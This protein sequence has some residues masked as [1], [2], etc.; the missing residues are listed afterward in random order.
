MTALFGYELDD[1]ARFLLLAC[2]G[3]LLLLLAT[4]ARR[5]ILLRIA[6]RQ[7]PRRRAQMLLIT[8]GLALGASIITSVFLTGDTVQTA[9]RVQVVEGLGRVDE[10]VHVAGGPYLPG[11]V[12]LTNLS[13][14]NT[15]APNATNRAVFLDAL[16][17]QVV[18]QQES[19]PEIYFPPAV[20]KSLR[21]GLRHSPTVAALLPEAVEHHALLTDETSRQ[22]RGEVKVIGLPATIPAAFGPL[23]GGNGRRLDVGSLPAGSVAIDQVAASDL[24]ARPGDRL[25]LFV[26]KQRVS[27]RL[28]AIVGNGGLAGGTPSLLMP[29]PTLSAL[30]GHPG[31]I[32][33]ILV[34]NRGADDAA[35]AA[36]SDQAAAE[37]YGLAPPSLTVDEAKSEGLRQA[38]QAQEIFSRIFTLFALFAAGVGLLLVFLIFTILAADRRP[39]MGIER[40]VGLKRRDLVAMY[41][42]EGT[43]YA[44][45]SAGLGLALGVGIGWAILTLLNLVLN[46]YGFT[47]QFVVHGRVAVIS[48]ALGLLATWFTVVLA[49]WWTTRLTVSSAIRDLPEPGELGAGPLRRLLR[50]W[51]A[52]RRRLAHREIADAV[53]RL[54]RD[55]LAG[56]GGAVLALVERGPALLLAGGALIR[57]GIDGGETVTFAAGV[58]VGLLGFVLTLRTVLRLRRVSPA[59]ADRVSFSL[60]GALLIAYWSLPAEAT[61]AIGLPPMQTGI[62]IFFVAGVAMVLGAVWIAMY[63]LDVLVRP[64]ARALALPGRTTAAVRT[65]AAYTLHRP[66]RTGMILAMFGLVSFTLTVMAVVTD[67]LQRTYGDVAAQTGGFDIRGDLLYDDPIPSIRA[68]VAG[69]RDLHAGAFSFI[70]SQGFTPVGVVQLSESSPAWRLSYAD[71]IDGDFLRGDGF[72]LLSTARGYGSDAQVWSALRHNSGL[73]LLGSDLLPGGTQ[74]WLQ[75]G[76][77]LPQPYTCTSSM[78]AG[79]SPFSLW[80]ADPRGGSAVKVRIIGLVDDSDGHHG[81]LVVPASLLAH[82]GSPPLLSTSYFRVKP[83]QDPAA[84]ARLLGSHFLEHGLQTTVLANAVWVQRGPRILLARLLQGFVGL[85]LLLGV[86]GLAAAAMRSVVER[87][88]QIGMMR[89]LGARRGTIR[90]AFLLES[91]AVALAGLLIGVSLGLLLARNLFLA[92]FF[93]QYQTGLTMEAPWRELGLIVGFTYLVSMLA[94]L[95]PARLAGAV[96]PV[97]ALMDR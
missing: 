76:A 15:G 82:A 18:G 95:L 40:V 34:V 6:L 92:D 64:L 12:D 28:A 69:A 32:D 54:P 57:L 73:A 91:S 52:L 16:S 74:Q 85:V 58:T 21:D 24:A 3:L 59:T 37:I 79:F 2:A 68:A 60:G 39:E 61:T 13:G 29:L 65:A 56:L 67:A 66:A 48:Y 4:A 72:H 94:T 70:G 75:G 35:A 81:G 78:A 42:Y 84:Q 8:L 96:S 71:V 17:G 25:L 43:A 44:V 10:I 5:P 63:N 31:A 30:A 83:G 97:E 38:E 89:A 55:L 77:Q 9:I 33:R 22:I 93:E 1:I 26:D 41:V 45:V 88:Q 51:S 20:Y 49:C 80:L 53:L 23:L 14:L 47:L 7:L 19:P 87:R 27:L 11:D 50:P 86:A 46:N 36:V 90:L 62:E